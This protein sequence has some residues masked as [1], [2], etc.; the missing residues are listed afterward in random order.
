VYKTF[1]PVSAV[2]NNSHRVTRKKPGLYDRL[3]DNYDVSP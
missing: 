1:T 2:S 3:A